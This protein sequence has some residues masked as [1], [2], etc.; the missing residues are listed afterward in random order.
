MNSDFLWSKTLDPVMSDGSTS[1]VN[2]I[3]PNS[4][5]MVAASARAMRVLPTPGTSSI[6]T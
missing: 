5:P 3:R 2:W 6:S 1:G 4:Q